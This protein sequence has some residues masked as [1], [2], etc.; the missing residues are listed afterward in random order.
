MTTQDKH[1]IEE[2][3]KYIR[4]KYNTVLTPPVCNDKCIT[5]YK[6]NNVPYTWYIYDLKSFL[7]STTKESHTPNSQTHINE[8]LWALLRTLNYVIFDGMKQSV[9]DAKQH[10]H[11]TTLMNIMYISNYVAL[12]ADAVDYLCKKCEELYSPINPTVV[13]KNNPFNIYKSPNIRDKF[14]LS[15]S[16]NLSAFMLHVETTQTSTQEK[17]LLNFVIQY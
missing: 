16:S 5:Y 11:M 4:E 1:S 17:Y 12:A 3:K 8:Y 15:V 9:F 14:Q 10:K 2:I 6:A 7:F 13:D